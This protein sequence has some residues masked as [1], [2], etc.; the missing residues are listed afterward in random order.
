MRDLDD[1]RAV[2]LEIVNAE[3]PGEEARYVLRP[4]DVRLRLEFTPA[5]RTALQAA[6]ATAS[7]DQRVSVES[8]P[9]PVD[10]DRVAEGVRSRCA[11]RFEY[12]GTAREV[13]PLSYSWRNGDVFL[14]ARE[15]DTEVVKSFSIRRMLDLDID[16]PGT[17]AVDDGVA[18][19]SLDPITWLVDPPVEAV[20]Y[21]PGFTEDVVAML[22][23]QAAADTVTT[24]VTNRLIFFAR[25]MEL[26]SRVRLDGPAEL[27]DQ[28][29]ERLREVM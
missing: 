3:G 24:T 12:N 17:A 16:E 25:L 29:R 15:R 28:L 1:L 7:R 19:P 11:M 26:G 27:R 23:G 8:T 5:Q 20:L 21:C 10:L 6:V 22:G 9:L 18:Q 13:D 4:G 2:G 14:V